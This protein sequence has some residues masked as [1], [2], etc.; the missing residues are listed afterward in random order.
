MKI[1]IEIEITHKILDKLLT[2]ME[3]Q[4]C[5]FIVDRQIIS[6]ISQTPDEWLTQ[7]RKREFEKKFNEDTKDGNLLYKVLT[8]KKVI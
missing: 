1:E 3:G 4:E 6:F 8:I 2:F 7:E 5:H